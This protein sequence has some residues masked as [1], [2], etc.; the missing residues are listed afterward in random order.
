MSS[1]VLGTYVLVS[2]F[3]GILIASFVLPIL[4]SEGASGYLV[5]VSRAF[6]FWGPVI[7]RAFALAFAAN[8]T[9]EFRRL[10]FNASKGSAFRFITRH[11]LRNGRASRVV[12]RRIFTSFRL[13]LREI[14][15]VLPVRRRRVLEFGLER[16]RGGAFRL[17]E[18]GVSTASGGRV[19]AATCGAQRASVNSSAQAFALRRKDRILHAVARWQRP[20][21]Y[22]NDGRRFSRFSVQGAFRHFEVGSFEV[23]VVLV[24]VQ[25]VL[26]LAFMKG[27]KS[28]GLA[29]S[30]GVVPFRSRPLFCLLARAFHP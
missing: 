26:L 29:W 28:R 22:R 8:G 27:A 5:I 7:C 4:F 30:V 24:S 25:A 3:T 2:C 6:L 21:L 13:C 23:G 17:E 20:L 1:T 18:R 12:Q 9:V 11:F 10:R 16:V 19:I 14:R 15:V